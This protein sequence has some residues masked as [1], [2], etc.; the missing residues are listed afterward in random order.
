MKTAI[1]VQREVYPNDVVLK[2]AQKYFK[3]DDLAQVWLNKYALKDSEGN[4]Y[5]N[6]LKICT[7]ELLQKLLESKPDM[8]IR[9]QKKRF[10]T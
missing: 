7:A 5:E 2:E 4:I 9:C 6:L 10:L 3:G 8:Q 1:N